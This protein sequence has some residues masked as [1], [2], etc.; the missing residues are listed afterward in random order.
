MAPVSRNYQEMRDRLRNLYLL[1][2][3]K[4]NVHPPND[5]AK[6]KQKDSNVPKPQ[7]PVRPTNPIP[8]STDKS[9]EFKSLTILY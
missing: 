5:A 7:P 8:M 1:K 2:K 4:Q 6:T 9:G 3:A